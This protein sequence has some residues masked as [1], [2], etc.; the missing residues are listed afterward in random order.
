[1]KWDV[2]EKEDHLLLAVEG[3]LDAVTAAE[4]N[5]AAARARETAPAVR[6]LVDLGGLEFISSA[7]LRGIL[8]L[9]KN[10]QQDS[11]PLAFCGLQ[12]MVADVF[13]ISGLLT[14][15]KVFPDQA[16]ALQGGW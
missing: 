5:S 3:R 4:F 11:R 7:G 6:L 2:T 8:S 16:A 14:I 15:L 1:M 12:P 13:K 9:A 10:F